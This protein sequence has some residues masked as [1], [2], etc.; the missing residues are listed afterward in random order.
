MVC[1]NSLRGQCY[2][3]SMNTKVTIVGVQSVNGSDIGC[4]LDHLINPFDRPDHFVALLFIVD[5]RA[6]VL[7]NFFV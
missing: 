1:V 5:W 7:A 2:V 3:I 4:T 6:F